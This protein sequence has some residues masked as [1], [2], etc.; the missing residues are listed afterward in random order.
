MGGLA[1]QSYLEA[2]RKPNIATA[3]NM[4]AVGVNLVF[5]LI[6]VPEHGA[7]GVVWAT[8]GSRWFMLVCFLIAVAFLTPALAQ[9]FESAGGR[10]QTPEHGRH[11]HGCREHRRV[12]LVQH[13]VR[14]RD[15]GLDRAR[16]RSMVWPCR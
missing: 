2:L 13:D 3:I 8:T 5:G 11:R 10:V 4:M 9:V 12:G 1:C 6:L 16:A 14:D 15:A 7:I